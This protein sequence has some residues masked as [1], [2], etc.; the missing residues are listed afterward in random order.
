MAAN[1]WRF[2]VPRLAVAIESL[3]ICV[4]AAGAQ[5]T[6]DGACEQ[7][8]RVTVRDA[9][10]ERPVPEVAVRLRTFGSP[11]EERSRAVEKPVERQP[12]PEDDHLRM[13][14][15]DARGEARFA[16]LC[17]GR[18]ALETVHVGY[19][20]SA[21][22]IVI[23]PPRSNGATGLSDRAVV[24][25]ILLAPQVYAVDAVDVRAET[26]TPL[27]SLE[28]SSRVVPSEAAVTFP[29]YDL[30]DAIR[31]VPGVLLRGDRVFFRGVATEHVATTIDGVPARHPITGEWILPPPEAVAGAELIASTVVADNAPSLGGLLALRLVEGKE[32]Q[33]SRLVYGTDAGWGE[34]RERTDTF[35]AVSAGPTSLPGLSYAGAYR[36][37]LQNSS[38]SYDRALPQQSILGFADVARR[39]NGRES[40]SFKLSWDEPAKQRWHAS[41]AVLSVS[42]R[43]K[44][45]QANYARSGWVGYSP[46]LDRYTRFLDEPP[47]PERDRFYEG[48]AHVPIE[49]SRSSIV[50]AT[51]RRDLGGATALQGYLFHGDHE[52]TTEHDV[53]LDSEAAIEAW[54]RGALTDPNHQEEAFF[55]LH[56]DLPIHTEGRSREFGGGVSGGWTL[57][58]HQLR[59]GVSAQRGRHRYLTV[60]PPPV[61]WIGSL[62]E[63]LSTWDVSGYLQDTWKTDERSW[64]QAAVRYDARQVRWKD[65]AS[66]AARWSPAIAFHQPMTAV[67]E[68]HVEVGQSYQF[69]AL[70]SHFPARYA[71]AGAPPLEAQRLRFAEVGFQHHFSRRAVVY[72]GARERQYLDVVFTGRTATALEELTGARNTPSGVLEQ[73]EL[74]IS[75]DL[76]ITASWTG[77]TSFVWSRITAEER[78]GEEREAPWS[79]RGYARSWLVW[80]AGHGISSTLAFS[81]D[82]GRPYDLCLTSRGCSEQQRIRGT[83]PSRASADWA[84]SWSGV[85]GTPL[86]LSVEV[87]NVFDSR[88]PSFEF[89]SFPTEATADHF[90]AYWDETGETGGY[91]LDHGD[92]RSEIELDNPQTR[93]PGRAALVALGVRF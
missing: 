35:T 15:T 90:L 48:P 85:A 88:P 45:F 17:P 32:R 19:L 26:V 40:A 14:F 69:P 37:L 65:R 11:S 42:E 64:L 67:D 51:A 80:R 22:E 92:S 24:M 21:R 83:L 59:A 77:Q 53:A 56:G 10:T 63:P 38:W 58:A 70:Q 54:E 43:G 66:F 62:E 31:L 82:S 1:V 20:V 86:E 29:G 52:L 57:S 74:E 4:G 23:P 9:V 13:R 5:M 41:G 25:E 72:L 3:L 81:W 78:S 60:I 46:E 7:T 36:G 50:Y 68:L 2:P 8:L 39:M 44:R 12:D 84:A 34:G 73:R 87:R 28:R 33:I 6:D 27:V 76:K 91:L 93:A 47:A 30:V 18:Y 75:L 61:W 71:A 89:S 79:R 55:A 49:E 16:D